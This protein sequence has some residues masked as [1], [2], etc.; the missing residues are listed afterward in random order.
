MKTLNNLLKHVMHSSKIYL[1]NRKIQIRAIK[2]Q[3]LRI[4]SK[5]FQS[6]TELKTHTENF[7]NIGFYPETENSTDIAEYFPLP[8]PSLFPFPF[9]FHFPFL[10]P[11][12]FSLSLLLFFSLI[13]KGSTTKIMCS[14]IYRNEHHST[15]SKRSWFKWDIHQSNETFSYEFSAPTLVLLLIY[16]PHNKHP[17]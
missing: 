1:Q 7:W 17:C 16:W 2:C 5:V 4:T 6:E 12:S 15:W 11:F 9:L 8:F 14:S 13:L 10:F 3:H